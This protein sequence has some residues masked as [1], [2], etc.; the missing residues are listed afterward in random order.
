M[1]H[2]S[3]GYQLYW[4]FLSLLLIT[5][6]G[7]LKNIKVTGNERVTQDEIIKATQ[8]DSRDYTLTTFLNRNQYVNNLW[9][10][11]NGLIEKAEISYQ[12]PITFKIQVTEFKILAYE[13]STEIYPVISNANL[14]LINQ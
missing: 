10:K 2:T 14:W 9:K 8:I 3:S 11:A 6:L 5:P 7:S 13:A 4:F 12:F 1:G